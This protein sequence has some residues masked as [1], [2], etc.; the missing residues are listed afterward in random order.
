MKSWIR[1]YTEVPDDPKLQTLPPD[2]FKFLIN[3]WCLT[4]RNGET[5]PPVEQVAWT[6]RMS[7]PDV[8][9]K[10]ADLRKRGLI[11]AV[12]GTFQ[13]HGW[14]SRQ[15]V[16][17]VSSERVKRHRERNGNATRNGHVTADETANVTPRETTLERPQRQRDTDTEAERHQKDA[18]AG[19]L[20]PLERT[21]TRPANGEE[22]EMRGALAILAELIPIYAPREPIPNAQEQLIVQLIIGKTPEQR[23]RIVPYVKWALSSGKW[24]SKMK[25]LRNLL[26]DG[27]FD[28]EITPEMHARKP[29]ASVSEPPEGMHATERGGK[30]VFVPN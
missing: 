23:A 12:S 29:A 8:K 4:G 6:L 3:C 25:G 5:L 13:P 28:I 10:L 11:D 2:L 9:D 17:D 26:N 21:A 1:L 27:D 18:P 15:Y 22:S 7:E 30:I 14:N 16:S 24:A 19:A 20:P